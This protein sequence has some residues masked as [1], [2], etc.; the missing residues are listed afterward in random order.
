MKIQKKKVIIDWKELTHKV[1][2]ELTNDVKK[3]LAKIKSKD[4]IL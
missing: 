4:M 2:L 1:D 3:Y